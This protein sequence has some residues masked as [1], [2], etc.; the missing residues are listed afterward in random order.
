MSEGDVV[1]VVEGSAAAP[2]DVAAPALTVD[3]ALKEV[4]KNALIADGLVRGVRESV[5]A[6]DKRQAHFCVLAESTD[7]AA[8][9]NL[10]E[11]L[12]A[13]HG[14]YLIKVPDGK[15]LGKL[16]GLCKIDREG[17]ARKIVRCA[18]AVVKDYGEDSAAVSVLLN[19]FKSRSA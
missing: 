12:C 14:I 8:V 18:V 13:E 10:I 17:E 2:V 15:E 4:L 5:K 3:E 1:E 11:A 16:V 19:H 9:K 7:E 6:L